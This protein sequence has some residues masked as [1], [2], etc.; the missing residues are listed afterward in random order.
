MDVCIGSILLQVHMASFLRSLN[1]FKTAN[2]RVSVLQACLRELF[3]ARK[4]EFR[5]CGVCA[6]VQYCC[7]ECQVSFGTCLAFT[8]LKLVKADT[9]R[10]QFKVDARR[11]SLI[12]FGLNDT[13][14]GIELDSVRLFADVY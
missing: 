10:L 7:R 2:Q 6:A 1:L 8:L 4:K 3:E 12:V 5:R 9:P 14:L 13:Y 11:T